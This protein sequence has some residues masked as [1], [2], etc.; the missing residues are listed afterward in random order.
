VAS[1][2]TSRP[3]SWENEPST[4]ETDGRQVP[5]PRVGD[6][7]GLTTSPRRRRRN[8]QI[9][10]S[11]LPKSSPCRC[12]AGLATARDSPSSPAGTDEPGLVCDDHCL[13]A[14]THVEPGEVRQRAERQT[15][16][17]PARGPPS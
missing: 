8:R 2:R 5:R 9:G 12:S 10:N 3:K 16:Q 4:N 17:G 7:P 11:A 6:R 1:P 13:G 14:V 15:A